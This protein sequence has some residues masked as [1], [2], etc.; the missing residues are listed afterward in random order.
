[1]ATNNPPTAPQVPESPSPPN[2]HNIPS[3]SDHTWEK[4]VA[5]TAPHGV[6][7]NKDLYRSD[8]SSDLANREIESS[9]DSST[10]DSDETPGSPTASET[11]SLYKIS[12]SAGSKGGKADLALK[13]KK[14]WWLIGGLMGI[15][16]PILLILVALFIMSLLQLPNYA[17]NIAVFR[18]SRSALQIARTSAEID[19]ERA[20]MKAAEKGGMKKF[21]SNT[22]KKIWTY[23][24]KTKYKNLVAETKITYNGE[25]TKIKLNGKD[26]VIR[27]KWPSLWEKY[28]NRLK[29]AADIQT[30]VDSAYRNYS[31]SVR[32]QIAKDLRAKMGIKL[33]WWDDKRSTYK[34]LKKLTELEQDLLEYRNRRNKISETPENNLKTAQLKRAA[35]EYNKILDDCEAKPKC[36]EKLAK[37]EIPEEVSEKLAKLIE[38]SFTSKA[39]GFINPIFE[40][41]VWLCMIYDGSMIRSGGSINSQ[42][43]AAIKSYHALEVAADQQKNGDTTAEAIG[44][45]N[46]LLSRDPKNKDDEA[47]INAGDSIPDQYMRGN[48]Q[49]DTSAE[50]GPQTSGFGD[51]TLLDAIPGI[52]NFAE[53]LEAVADSFCPTLTDVKFMA[54]AGVGL[55]I[56]SLIGSGGAANIGEQA[57]AQGVKV[58]IKTM[59]KKAFWALF[60][61]ATYKMLAKKGWGFLRKFARDF[62]AI[63][64]IT[65]AAKLLVLHKA[66]VVNDGATSA[67]SNFKN[68]ADMGGDLQN[69]EMERQM[70]YG[71]PLTNKQALQ[72]D[73]EVIAY[74]E[75]QDKLK[76]ISERYFAISNPRSL[77]SKLGYQVMYLKK[78]SAAQ[79]LG[80][81]LSMANLGSLVD[82]L[83]PNTNKLVLAADGAVK[84]HYGILQW[85]WSG[86]D[87]ALIASDRTFGVLENAE[88]LK[89]AESILPD[90][91]PGNTVQEIEDKYSI[92]FT[93]TMG[94]LLSGD[95]KSSD[96]KILRDDNG[97]VVVNKRLCSPNNLGPN[98]TEF[99]IPALKDAEHMVF[100]WRLNKMRENV[101]DEKL[102][103][104][105]PTEDSAQTGATSGEVAS[106]VEIAKREYNKH[107]Q[108][109]DS[110]V[111]K[112]T[113]NNKWAWC[114]SFAS[115]VYKEAGFP[116]T[117]GDAN[118]LHSGVTDLIDYFQAHEI[119]FDFG[120]QDPQ[121]GDM[122]MYGCRA[123][124]NI[125]DIYGCDPGHNG[126]RHVA[127]VESYDASTKTLTAIGGNEGGVTIKRTSFKVLAD[128][129]APDMGM[130]IA[131]FGRIKQ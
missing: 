50:K 101:L 112:Y 85:G 42:S 10:E 47:S 44:A 123:N 14:K 130:C 19:S 55:F 91:T 37:G 105:N 16:T 23:E 62:A 119:Y 38:P 33:I 115:W 20:A 39:I 40:I 89:E 118:W 24:P 15:L 22:A 127:I 121:P 79:Y 97:D 116:L 131:G 102:G 52:S 81:F 8:S 82:S 113:N 49:P 41:A 43:D 126:M 87:R 114:A 2:R 128:G 61:K 12:N 30:Y 74:L 99:N 92:C 58:F 75:S 3:V 45:F 98:N 57:I 124:P 18:L 51:Y 109:W 21:I 93:A 25:I 125:D 11:K 28:P 88:I 120:T 100:R 63:E 78:I 59:I 6:D 54:L 90:G 104:Q 69:N 76:P 96:V 36:L 31:T 60:E 117:K 83:T 34:K 110:D 4:P 1:M 106:I 67:S 111:L 13:G 95:G 32:S 65:G 107:P 71:A 80:K 17:S 46:R 7:S 48:K 53:P 26:L 73:K 70:L 68:Q 29:M 86:E 108:E 56:A 103:I 9:A 77:L 5:P 129:C 35:D 94:S 122:V 66:F 64:I 72:G 27:E 84:S